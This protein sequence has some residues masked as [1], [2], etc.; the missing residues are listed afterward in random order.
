MACTKIKKAW[1][2]ISHH[3][4]IIAYHPIKHKFIHK[5]EFH[6]I[7]KSLGMYKINVYVCGFRKECHIHKQC[8]LEPIGNRE[9]YPWNMKN[10]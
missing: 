8:I 9:S 10:S 5:K 1:N 6:T 7:L 2:E 4:T 3:E